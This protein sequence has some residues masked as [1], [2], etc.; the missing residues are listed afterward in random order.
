MKFRIGIDIRIP[1]VLRT[2]TLDIEPLYVA[3]HSSAEIETVNLCRVM[4][5]GES[6]LLEYCSL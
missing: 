2:T 3:S 6:R 5:L 4:H 1:F